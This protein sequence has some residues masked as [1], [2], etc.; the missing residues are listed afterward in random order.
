MTTYTDTPLRGARSPFAGSAPRFN[1]SVHLHTGGGWH[2]TTSLSQH[3]GGHVIVTGTDLSDV[4]LS[5]RDDEALL[6]FLR[7]LEGLHRE[8]LGTLYPDEADPEAGGRRAVS[9]STR[10]RAGATVDS[11]GEV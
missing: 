10:E 3:G 2:V 6:G 5:F 1:V 4:L 11:G 8:L 9:V 7:S